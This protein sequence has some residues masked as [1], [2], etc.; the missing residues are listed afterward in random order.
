MNVKLGEFELHL[1]DLLHQRLWSNARIIYV[2]DSGW[3]WGGGLT[4]LRQ[5]LR[6]FSRAVRAPFY[7]QLLG[8]IYSNR[9]SLFGEMNSLWRGD[10][11]PW[12]PWRLRRCVVSAWPHVKTDCDGCHA[13]RRSSSHIRWMTAAF[14]LRDLMFIQ[15]P[16]LWKSLWE[17][18]CPV[19]VFGKEGM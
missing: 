16:L 4:S 3:K 1:F 9:S 18:F 5:K 8:L 17:V 13:P 10:P 2:E 19:S 11:S 7:L 15:S 12:K 6:W 14:T